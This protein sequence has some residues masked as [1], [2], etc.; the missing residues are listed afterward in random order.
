MS[1]E[2]NDVTIGAAMIENHLREAVALTRAAYGPDMEF[3]AVQWLLTQLAEVLDLPE[4]LF[5]PAI[6]R[7]E[8]LLAAESRLS[9]EVAAMLRAAED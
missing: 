9:T 7:A 8:A 4:G 6:D 3:N 5:Y 1:S 2:L